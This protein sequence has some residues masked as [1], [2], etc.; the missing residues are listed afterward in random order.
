MAQSLS[1]LYVHLVFH[2][3][4]NQPLI[5]PEIESELFSYMGGII[6]TNDSIPIL[7]N[8]TEN[9][10]HILAILSKNIA[11]SKFSEEIK[12]NSSRWIK[13]KGKEYSNFQWQGGYAG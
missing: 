8:G 13:T 6:K 11:L 12:K 10:I 7:I 4:H 9:H 2:T 1:K 5:R 3:K